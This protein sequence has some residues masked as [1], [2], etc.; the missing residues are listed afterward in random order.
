[1]IEAEN[2][3]KTLNRFL[4]KV[5]ENKE[6]GCYEWIGGRSKYGRFWYNGKYVSSHR[7]AYEFFVEKIPENLYMLHKCD[8]PRCVCPEHLFTGTNS[9][10]MIDCAMKDRGSKSKLTVENVIIVKKMLK[11][12]FSVKIIASMFEITTQSI[13]SI[14]LNET[15]SRITI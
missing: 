14:K 10:N 13:Y 12:G 3:L 7:F 2:I 5:V 9:D 6:T 15:W 11:R 8:N 4:N 1:M